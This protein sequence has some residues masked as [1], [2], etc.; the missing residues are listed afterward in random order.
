MGSFGEDVGTLLKECNGP[1]LTASQRGRT[2]EDL[3]SVVFSAVPGLEVRALNA[4][5]VFEN[6][7]LDLV[8]R[9]V[10]SQDGLRGVGAFF[11]VECKNWSR[12]VGSAEVSWFATKLRRSGQ[13]F[14]VLVAPAGITGSRS[15]MKAAHFEAAA[16]LSE[17]QAIAVLTLQEVQWLSSGEDLA[18]LLLEK[19]ARLVARREVYVANDRPSALD[20]TAVLPARLRIE[21]RQHRIK[22]LS[23]IAAEV[24]GKGADG[25]SRLVDAVESSVDA[26]LDSESAEPTGAALESFDAWSEVNLAALE[27]VVASLEK[28]ARA[29]VACLRHS[30]AREWDLD[31]LVL[32][33]ETRA[34]SNLEAPLDSKFARVIT[35]FWAEEADTRDDYDS[36]V[37]PL[38]L[39][40]WSLDSLVAIEAGAWPPPFV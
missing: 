25:F 37:P 27:A 24:S 31:A 12:P 38:C 17:G 21:Y 16:A 4:K 35:R 2:L 33:L 32:G 39:L 9:N 19:H 30:R 40:S 18:D 28:L 36:H 7:E 15:E 13:T 34:P 3:I 20:R 14:G 22:T 26:F 6:E 10:E 5:S 11:S 1:G 8:V 29:C 23:R